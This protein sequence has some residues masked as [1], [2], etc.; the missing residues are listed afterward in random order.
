MKLRQASLQK[1]NSEY[2]SE[3]ETESWKKNGEGMSNVC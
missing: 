1:N 3:D 2:D